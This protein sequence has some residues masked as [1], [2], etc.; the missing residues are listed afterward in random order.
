MP[1]EY[2]VKK[3]QLSDEEEKF[4]ESLK[5]A[6]FKTISDADLQKIVLVDNERAKFI[7]D[8]KNLL[9]DIGIV[10]LPYNK[11]VV[12]PKVRI[13]VK[14][15]IDNPSDQLIDEVINYL[16]SL[17]VISPLME[18]PKVEEI[19]ING[20]GTPVYV[21]HRD[22]G[23]CR[24]NLII[25]SDDELKWLVNRILNAS[26][27]KAG[28]T[29]L[30]DG[31]LEDS[32]RFNIVLPPLSKSPVVTMRRFTPQPFSLIE[33]VKNNTMDLNIAAFLWLAVEGMNVKPANILVVGGASSGKTT[34][35]NAL[36]GFV[37]SGA[38]IITI[39]DVPELNLSNRENIISLYTQYSRDPKE[40]VTLQDLVKA[41]LRMRPDRVIVGEVRGE[42]AQDLFVAMDI[43]CS[44]SMG[45]L[46]ANS[47]KETIM[48]LTTPPMNVPKT[49]L[50]LVDLII[51]Q[52]R[53]NIP[54]KGLVRRVTE[55]VEVGYIDNINFTSIFK[56]IP[57][58]DEFLSYEIPPTYLDKLAKL[59]GRTKPDL[60][61]ELELR[62]RI[63]KTIL[64]DGILSFSKFYTEAERRLK[65]FT[66]LDLSNN[67]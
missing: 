31:S 8:V 54:G 39:E 10:V 64:D 62:K 56:W 30:F 42:E 58:K 45:T 1:G 27:I 4:L 34:T 18:D 48:R 25:E 43:G 7:S 59:T 37:P 61:K 41:S 57:E 11:D 55:V 5:N 33:L 12:R 28:S 23:V 40:I 65:S 6:T 9:S 13:F 38:R 29:R 36:L 16:F 53:M 60:M 52:Q 14:K 67:P 26:I 49:L 35:L 44:G 50:P 63:L 66:D 46:H 21:V 2:R 47:A 32:T 15:Y 19:M 17:G 20:S 24:T 22:I 3:V 51:V